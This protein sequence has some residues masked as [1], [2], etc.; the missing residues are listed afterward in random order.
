[1]KNSILL[2]RRPCAH[3]FSWPCRQE[4]LATTIPVVASTTGDPWPPFSVPC[5]A[6]E[7]HKWWWD[8][9]QRWLLSFWLG[10]LVSS[11]PLLPC[12]VWSDRWSLAVNPWRA[13][14]IRSRADS[15][16]RRGC[17]QVV[18]SWREVV[19]QWRWPC[20]GDG[21]GSMVRLLGD[22]GANSQTRGDQAAVTNC[23]GDVTTTNSV[24]ELL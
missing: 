18:A 20:N 7:L 24:S 8:F 5:C 13:L 14:R 9:L 4:N 12:S 21:D 16:Q 23:C 3:V 6:D 15:R 2:W 1:M 22:N 11:L 10:G 19:R 17:R